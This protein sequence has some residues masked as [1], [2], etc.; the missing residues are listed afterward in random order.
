MAFT[1]A[2]WARLAARDFQAAAGLA[3]SARPS[4]VASAADWALRM[5]S[6]MPTPSK[7]LPV[8]ISRGCRAAWRRIAAIRSRWPSVYWGMARRVAADLHQKGRAGDAK[9]VRQLAPDQTGDRGVVEIEQLGLHRSADEGPHQDRAGGARWANFTL[10]NET[11]RIDRRSI[12]GTTAP[13]PSSG[14]AT[15]SRRYPTLTMTD[16]A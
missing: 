3:G 16:E 2:E 1:R 7:A 12:S 6:G 8:R 11:A 13:K 15:W 9:Q 5:T 10:R 14:W 4:R